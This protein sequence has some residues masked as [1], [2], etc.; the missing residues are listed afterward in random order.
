MPTV[1]CTSNVAHQNVNAHPSTAY[2]SFKGQSASA[3]N[4]SAMS[5][6]VSENK[7][8]DYDCESERHQHTPTT[9]TTVGINNPSSLRQTTT[10][11]H[12]TKP[13][14]HHQSTT[15]QPNPYNTTASKP[16]GMVLNTIVFMRHKS[17]VC[18][19]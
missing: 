6:G 1:S 5:V 10:N 4:V 15:A 19:L 3:A 17:T 2:S 13:N 18:G 16:E 9:T 11:Y 7:N 14:H 12:A 8:D